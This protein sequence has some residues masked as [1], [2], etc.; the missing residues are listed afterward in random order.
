[1]SCI[2]N[3]ILFSCLS[4][5]GTVGLVSFANP[6]SAAPIDGARQAS[7][8]TADL[9]LTHAAG[10]A[11]FERRVA[12]AARTVCGDATLETAS[13]VT[14]CRRTAAAQARRDAGLDRV[15]MID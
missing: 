5:A 9:D 10:Q 12:A 8:V 15:A 3:R 4:V 13:M 1:M 14:S 2:S 6:A 11:T 7:V